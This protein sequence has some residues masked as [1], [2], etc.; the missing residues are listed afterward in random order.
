MGRRSALGEAERVELVMALLRKEASGSELSRRYGV[1]EAT[2]YKWRDEFINGGKQSLKG[3]RSASERDEVKQLKKEL[4]EHKQLIGEYVFAND[5]LKKR[6][7]RS[8]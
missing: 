5:F 7:E 1:S 2:M 8:P 3:K 4:A 6:L